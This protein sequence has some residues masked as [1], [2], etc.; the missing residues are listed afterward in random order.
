MPRAHEPPLTGRRSSPGG[1]ATRVAK[2][3]NERGSFAGE[4]IRKR[5]GRVRPGLATI[6]LVLAVLSGCGVQPT[7]NSPVTFPRSVQG[8]PIRHLAWDKTLPYLDPQPWRVVKPKEFRISPAA[9]LEKVASYGIGLQLA[10]LI[11]AQPAGL[12]GDGTGNPPAAYLI[13][14]I[15][16]NLGLNAAGPNMPKPPTLQFEVVAVNGTAGAITPLTGG[17]VH[18]VVKGGRQFHLYPE[19]AEAKVVRSVPLTNLPRIHGIA[20]PETFQG[21][22]SVWRDGSIAE[23]DEVWLPFYVY[24][25]H[26]G[27]TT[28]IGTVVNDLT[29]LSLDGDIQ[30]FP[31]PKKVG[32]IHITGVQGTTVSFRT[33][34]GLRGTLSVGTGKWAFKSGGPSQTPGNPSPASSECGP[35]ASS[36]GAVGQAL[37]EKYG[38]FKTCG[39][40]GTD[41][42]I[43]TFGTQSSS[44]VL[45]IYAC[46]SDTVCLNGQNPHPLSGWKIYYPPIPGQVTLLAARGNTVWVDVSGGEYTFDLTTLTWGKD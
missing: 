19:P 46:G 17:E 38:F 44:G 40:V 4:P 16:A 42:V 24:S 8:V 9:A 29:E 10:Q 11:Y 28:Y 12:L 18:G 15:G 37:T 45:A 34:T 3:A 6:C 25:S 43:P 1:L 7:A 35:W 13:E 27:V 26:Q 32:T 21:A 31:C 30:Q 2:T 41:W 23:Y 14:S 20:V 22:T 39:L 33:S 36:S 5:F